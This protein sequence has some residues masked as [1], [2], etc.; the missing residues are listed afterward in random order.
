MRVFIV[1]DHPVVREG[2]SHLF[3]LVEGIEPVGTAGDGDEALARIGAARPDIVLLDMQL[4]GDDGAV[5]TRRI[6]ELHPEA[7]VI[8]FTGGVD[9]DQVARARAA[10]AEGILLKTTP[11]ANL[12]RAL[13]E[14]LEGHQ[15]VDLDL[16]GVLQPVGDP[17]GSSPLSERE[18]EV[19]RLLA[20]GM[21][22][23]E[24]AQALFISRAT[25]K[26]HM[27]NIL[28]KLGVP[29][30]AAAVAE[31]FRRGLVG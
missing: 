23:K 25:V 9:R 18:L 1:D 4:P 12:I 13:H 29:D 17:D 22:N 10:G 7:R 6:K 11:V 26:S 3:Q 14:V 27:E 16:T 31:G 28:R 2:F 19:L 24:L 21:S 15:V 8:I 20:E 5:V 30:R